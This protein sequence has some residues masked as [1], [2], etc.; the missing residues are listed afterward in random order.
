M[1]K[2]PMKQNKLLAS[3][4]ASTL[5]AAVAAPTASWAQSADATLRGKAPDNARVTARNVATG[6][7]RSTQ[8][9]ADGTYVLAGLSPG[10]YKVDAGSGTERVVTLAVASTA[11]LDLVAGGGVKVD[12][13]DLADITVKSQKLVEVKTSEIGSVVSIDQIATV[14][15][16]TRNFL[17][18]ADTV[19]GIVFSVDS[20]GNTS[21]QSGAQA[22]SNINVYI[23]GVGQKNYVKTGGISGQAGPSGNGDPGN[24][25]PQ[26][27]ISEYK[28][29]TSNYK[30]EYDQ[31]SSAAITAQTKSGT[32]EFHGEIF[33]DYTSDKF[34]SA[35]PAE[36][37]AGGSKSPSTS[38]EWGMALGGPIM[39]DTAHFFATWEHKE[40]NL[41]N[42]VNPPGA[43]LNANLQS[44]LPADVYSQFGPSVNPF[45]EDL[46]FAKIDVEPSENDRIEASIKYRKEN[47][48]LG[49]SGQT[50]ASAAFN[51]NNDDTR[52]AVKWQHATDRWLN[53]TT[54]TYE[55]TVDNPT[56]LSNNPAI[57]YTYFGAANGQPTDIITINGQDPRQYT[58]KH[59]SGKGI[60]DDLTFSNVEWHGSHTFKMG[61][62][63]KSVELVAR[64]GSDAAKYWY[65]VTPNGVAADPFQV[66]FGKVNN[67]L[68]LAAVSD[69]KQF[70]VYFQDDWAVDSH[71]TLNL[72]V[73]W[74]YEQT[75]SFT[76]YVTPANVVAALGALYPDPGAGSGLPRPTSGETY[77]QALAAGGINMN[78]YI[79]NGHN[80]SNPTGEIA[81]RLGFSYDLDAD[82]KHVIFGGIGRAY[83]RNLF[84]RLQL[85]NSKNALSEPSILF[86][87]SGY[88]FNGG[89]A[90]ASQANGNTCL[91]W[92]P[93]YLNPANLQGLGSGVGEVDVFPNK[94]K[95]P[96][97]DQFSLGMRNKIGDWNTSAT[98]ARINSYDGIL[99]T[100]GNRYADGS[101]A[102]SG[103]GAA[104]GGAPAQWC[105]S[106]VPGIGS[107]IVWRNGQNTRTTELLLSA[108]KP[109]T[110]ESHWGATV[111][112]TYTDAKQNRLYTDGY[113]FDLP[114]LADYPYTLSNAVAIHRLVTTGMVDGP[115]GLL[116][117]A[118]LTL[119]TPL[120]YTQ[121]LGCGQLGAA[122]NTS[123]NAAGTNAYPGAAKFK[124]TLGYKALDLQITKNFEVAAGYT[125][126]ARLDMLNI[127]NAHNF[128]STQ[129]SWNYPAAP[130]YNKTGPIIGVPRTL[131]F[132]VGGRF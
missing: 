82:Q 128:D 113:A 39:K 35:T 13:A 12:A 100:L 99:G 106:G 31:I 65:A 77:L 97:S 132:T 67:G 52:A 55:K 69:N 73:R 7:S 50:A 117:A 19:P 114:T 4:I 30:A 53:E 103:C 120:P 75:P 27:A 90:S 45:K 81:P 42:T 1:T 115:W 123:C 78:D 102:N 54:L 28:V 94:I 110:R 124:E 46:Y 104:W 76:D 5:A 89:C 64:D 72:G 109:Y 10:V 18:F 47:E 74:D 33:G 6:A 29:I 20:N 60:Q 93:K 8:A 38:K 71:L 70:G 101:F 79:S 95:T 126:Y 87:N 43:L 91:A 84:D 26:L 96:Y 66:V 85:E 37:A 92:D 61:A 68:P 9:A 41:P 80:R 63:L 3:V 118:K 116:L 56:P 44:I 32:N 11:T 22:N 127:T 122:P 23:D 112:Y 49:A 58:D 121:I 34:R 16:I 105:S 98:I 88:T 17:E 83:D 36:E 130:E 131:K 25:F 48:Q 108:D 14:P 24:P 40:F 2:L 119:S 51:F 57:T 15:Q 125:L 107:L 21:V 86:Y 62:K 59:Q 129:A 111:A